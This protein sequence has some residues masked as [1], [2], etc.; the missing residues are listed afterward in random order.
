MRAPVLAAPS[1]HLR[2]HSPLLTAEL[3]RVRALAADYRAAGLEESARHWDG[4][5]ARLAVAV[6]GLAVSSETCCSPE[7]PEV[8]P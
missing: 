2:R 5:A 7:S 4:M 6:E 1:P 8:T 3:R